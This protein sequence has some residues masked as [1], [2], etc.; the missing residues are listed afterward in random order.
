MGAPPQEDVAD[1]A[2]AVLLVVGLDAV[3]DKKFAQRVANLVQHA[4]LQFAV[5]AGHD[6]VG[7]ARVKADAGAA[8]FVLAHREL[9]LVAVAVYFQRGQGGEDRHV[10]PADAAEGILYVVVLGP[11]F[12]FVAQVPQAAAAAGPGSGAVYLHPVG[13]RDEHLVQNAEG[14]ALAVFDDL[15]PGL[16][17][18][19]GV[20]H[21]DGLAVGRVGHA[22]AVVGKPLDGQFKQLVF[23]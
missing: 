22:A 15:H 6:A 11:Q 20:G 10:Q 16:V 1:K 2:L 17:A 5:G 9:H 4:G 13:G 21:K 12:G 8:V 19:G 18:G 23:L 3:G 14:V 7:A